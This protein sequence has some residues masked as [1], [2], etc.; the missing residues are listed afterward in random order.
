MI[1]EATA[2]GNTIEE[3]QEA[4]LLALGAPADAD[5][6]FEIISLPQKKKLGL[7]GGSLAQVKAF[8]TVADPKPEAKPKKDKKPV[9]EEKTVKTEVKEEKATEPKAPVVYDDEQI[10]TTVDYL[11]NMLT[12]MGVTNLEID[13][14][15]DDDG[16][17]INFDGDGL[18]VAIGRKGETLD[19]IQHLTSLVANRSHNDYV[20]VTLNPG[21]YRQKR[22]ETLIGIV[23]RSAEQALK[24]KRNVI[25]DPMNSYERRIIHNTVQDIEGVTSWSIGENEHRRVCIGTGKDNK[26]FEPNRRNGRGRR[27][28]RK[29]ESQRVNAAPSREPRKD[30]E[31]LPLYGIIK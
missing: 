15:T 6:D 28:N 4:A 17:K 9:K 1:I 2:S 20:R 24:S 27:D 23:T 16:I 14:V 31:D 21:G 13:V 5:V 11:K 7:F 26:P 18:G 25:L 29:K 3:A 8:A 10:N 30:T 12:L 19:S 22:E